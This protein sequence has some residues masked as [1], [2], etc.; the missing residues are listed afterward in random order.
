[1]NT[2]TVGNESEEEET[3]EEE[4]QAGERGAVVLPPS[5]VSDDGVKEGR[6]EEERWGSEESTY[7]RLNWGEEDQG[8][9]GRRAD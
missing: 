8:W 1:M 6:V 9:A 7:G 2:L 5:G 4:V 3:S